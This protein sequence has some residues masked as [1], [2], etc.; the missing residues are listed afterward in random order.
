MQIDHS[1]QIKHVLYGDSGSR[2]K[3]SLGYANGNVCHMQ[4][5]PG[6]QQSVQKSVANLG[7][8]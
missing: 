1:A 8:S 6:G 5:E 4:A 7:R 3:K 2:S